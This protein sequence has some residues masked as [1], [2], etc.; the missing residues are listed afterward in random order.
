[1]I[2]NI[3]ISKLHCTAPSEISRCYVVAC[4]FD[5][6]FYPAVTDTVWAGLWPTAI[7]RCYERLA[8]VPSLFVHSFSSPSSPKIGIAR[9]LDTSGNKFC[10]AFFRN[11]PNQLNVPSVLLIYVSTPGNSA[12]DFEVKD[13]TSVL[14]SAT[15]NPGEILNI[16]ISTADFETF[17]TSVGKK[18]I[19]I[20]TVNS[21]DSVQVFGYSDNKDTADIFLAVPIRRATGITS[22]D[23][24]QFS[25]ETEGTA[26]TFVVTV[27]DVTDEE[28][29]QDIT[30][31]PT[32]AGS[33]LV[34]KV[35]IYK[36]NRQRLRAE[37]LDGTVQTG[38]INFDSPVV[39]RPS[40]DLT[41]FRV[42]TAIPSGV[43]IGHQCGQVPSSVPTCDYM[44]EQCPPS[45]TW[46]YNFITSGLVLRTTGYV[47]KIIPRYV[48]NVTMVTSFCDGDTNLTTNVVDRDGLMIDVETSINCYFQTSRPSGMVQYAKGQQSDDSNRIVEQNIGDPAMAWIAPVGQYINR[49]TFVTGLMTASYG[50]YTHG[51][52]IN[53]VV[54]AEFFNS[55]MIRL[56]DSVLVG[57][58]T[59]VFC[60]PGEVCAYATDLRMTDG[61]H[62]L[63]HDNPDGRLTVVVYG[64]AREKGYMYPAG[65]AMDPIGGN[66]V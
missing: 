23:Y 41:G 40:F 34:D 50:L 32:V 35:L 43:M 52:F 28:S 60:S 9:S 29:T 27:C 33:E 37:S 8:S 51:E 7:H 54:P 61:H 38:L 46:G 5:R 24:A 44:I 26:S 10:V 31:F 30:Y 62:V 48:N 1:M 21:N 20:E 22:Y 65:F 47:V 11:D 14:K 53:V 66:Y 63:E 55:S 49:I 39:T 15:V 59:E 12:V 42:S 57:N 25:T 16:T 13:S 45:Y 3:G 56:D 36:T 58:W 64:F 2:I 4:T 19:V 18:T 6:I 17:S